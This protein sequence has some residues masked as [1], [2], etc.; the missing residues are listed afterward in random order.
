MHCGHQHAGSAHAAL[1]SATSK[2]C[3]LQRMQLT[4]DCEPFN[5]LYARA[6]GLQHGHKAAVHQLAIHVNRTRAAF[7]FTA[8]FLRAGQVQIFAQYIQQPLHRRRLHGTLLSIHVEADCGETSAH[9]E[10]ISAIFWRAPSF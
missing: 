4:I 3:L 7:A 8:T 10:A 2:K 6:F 9:T 1:R 5:R